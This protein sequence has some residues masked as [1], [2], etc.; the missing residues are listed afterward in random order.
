M[1]SIGRSTHQART[2]TAGGWSELLDSEERH[3]AA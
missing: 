3:V 2:A 1:L